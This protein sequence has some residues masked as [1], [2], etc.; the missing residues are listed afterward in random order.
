[1]FV[2]IFGTYY[3]VTKSAFAAGYETIDDGDEEDGTGTGAGTGAGTGRGNGSGTYGG[4]NE[5]AALSLP[6]THYHSSSS[7]NSS[8]NNTSHPGAGTHFNSR[9][10]RRIFNEAMRARHLP[11][12]ES[13]R[14]IDPCDV[15]LIKVIGQGSFGRVYYGMCICVFVQFICVHGG[16]HV[17]QAGG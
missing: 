13:L 12:H 1:M 17:A 2:G 8:S 5:S 3:A 16:L 10:F 14:H 7:N 6:M 9:A 11:T 4:N 15:K